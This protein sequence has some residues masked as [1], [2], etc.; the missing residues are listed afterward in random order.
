M[1]G[2]RRQFLNKFGVSLAATAGIL[3]SPGKVLAGGWGR[4]RRCCCP[5]PFCPAPLD[6]RSLIL[7]PPYI[8]GEVAP[9]YPPPVPL[10]TYT[11][12]GNGGFYCW[13]QFGTTG[14]TNLSVQA[15]DNSGNPLAS[16]P[17]VQTVTTLPTP[18]DWALAVGNYANQSFYLVY[19]YT[20]NGV[21]GQTSV[22]CG[23]YST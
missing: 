23:P 4:R 1:P 13:G 19:T 10:G 20:K 22:V 14:I 15:T 5:P 16:Q 18:C 8:A 11:I 17:T 9:A 2:T 3:L 7:R 12:P 21:P 6:G